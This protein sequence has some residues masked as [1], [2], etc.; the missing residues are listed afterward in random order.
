MKTLLDTNPLVSALLKPVGHSGQIFQRWRKGE[1][2]LAVSPS[3]LVELDDVLHR[4]HIIK[5]YPISEKDIANHV[6]VLRDFAQVATGNLIVSAIHDDPKDNHVLAA[7]IETNCI[8]LVS[9]D[10]HLLNLDEYQGIKIL[11][12]RAFL[13]LLE[14]A[15]KSI[16]GS[17]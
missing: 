1:F 4:P 12:P 10:R 3:T 9:G 5:K 11:T 8:Y 2:E 15:S 16:E 17:N 14:A 7:A 13:E 6:T